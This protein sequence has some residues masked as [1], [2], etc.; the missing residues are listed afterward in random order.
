MK[1]VILALAIIFNALANVLIKYGV[2]GKSMGSAAAFWKSMLSL[3]VVGGAAAFI[4]ALGAYA[5]TLSRMDLS[6]AYPVMTSSG[7]I[8]IGI[9]SSAIFGEPIGLARLTGFALLIAGI[10]LIAR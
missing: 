6:V 5:Y 7:L 3:P 4:V 10:V 2:A 8:L 1:W 9:A